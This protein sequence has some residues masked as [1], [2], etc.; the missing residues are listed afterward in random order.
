MPT[1]TCPKC[2][3]SWNGLKPEHCRVC[4]ETFGGTAAGDKHRTGEHAVNE[5]PNRRRCRTPEEMNEVGL[6][7]D[8]KGIWRNPG[9]EEKWWENKVE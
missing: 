1:A 4:H 5:G 8:P 6:Q 9:P 3:K 2:Q 7:Q